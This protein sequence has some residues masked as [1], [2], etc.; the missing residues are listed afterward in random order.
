MLRNAS[1]SVIR[2]SEKNPHYYEYK[3]KEILLIT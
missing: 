2:V 1:E 3:G